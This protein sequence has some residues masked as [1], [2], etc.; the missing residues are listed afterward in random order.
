MIMPGR[1]WVAGIDIGKTIS[2]KINAFA[3]LAEGGAGHIFRRTK[4]KT[5]FYTQGVGKGNREGNVALCRDKENHR[6]Q[7]VRRITKE[8]AS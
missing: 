6:P 1:S 2:F 8:F 5:L 4:A 7:R 3:E